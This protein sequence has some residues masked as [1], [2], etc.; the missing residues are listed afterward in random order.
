MLGKRLIILFFT[1]YS[2]NAIFA[3]CPTVAANF[4]VNQSTFCG[5]G[6]HTVNFANTSSGSSLTGLTFS[7]YVNG[8]LF[9]TTTALAQTSTYTISGIGDYTFQLIVSDPSIP[10]TDTMTSIVSILAPPT[11]SFTIPPGSF[12]TNNAVAFTN[13]S[14]NVYPSTTYLWNFGDGGTSTAANPVYSYATAGTYTV[15]LTTSNGGPCTSVSTQ[16][17]TIINGPQISISGDD[18]DGDVT[19][20]LFPADNTTSEIVTFSNTTTNAVSYS[21]N[22]GD[23]SPIFNTTSTAPFTHLYSSYGTY[24][25]T[26][27]ATSAN[28]CQDTD[29]LIVIFEKY[30]SS[31][32]TLHITEYSGCI[33]HSITTLTNLSVNASLFTWNFGDGTIITTTS[34]VPPVHNYLIGGIYTITLT[35]ANS[36]NTSNATISPITIISGPTANFTPSLFNGCAPQNVTFVNTSSNVQPP[37]NYQWNM[38][39]GNTYTNVITPPGQLYNSSGTYT[40]QLIAGNACGHDTVEQTIVMDTIPEIELDLLPNEGCSPLTVDPNA[41]QTGGFNNTWAWAIDGAFYSATP[42]DI[43]NQVFTAT[44]FTDTSLHTIQVTVSNVCGTNSDIDTVIVHPPVSANFVAVDTLCTNSTLNFTNLSLG[45]DLSYVWDFGDGSPLSTAT[46]PSHI[47]TAAGTYTVSLT[48]TGFC[49][50][51]VYTET[52]VVVDVPSI[53]ISASPSV[54]CNNES[55]TF[56]NLSSSSG[57]FNWNFGPSASLTTSNLYTPPSVTFFGSNVTH[58]VYFSI[59]YGGCNNIDSLDIV[60]NTSPV[61]S[62][63]VTPNNGC[64]PISVAINNT[65]PN[66]V[67]QTYNWD[68]GNGGTSTGISPLNQTYSSVTVDTVYQIALLVENA[69]GCLDSAFQSIAVYSLPIADFTLVDDTICAGQASSVINNSINASQYNWNFGDGNTGTGANPAHAFALPGDYTIQMIAQTNNNCSDTSYQLIH[70]DSLPITTFSANSVCFG[71]PTI[72]TQTTIS[73]Q[74]T[75]TWDFGD[76]SALFTGTNPQHAY[77]SAGTYTATLTALN[78]YGCSSL[79][80]YSVVVQTSPAPDFTWAPTC[81]GSA[82]TFS[83]LTPGFFMTH[84]WNFGDGTSQTGFN[85]SHIY[86]DTGTYFVTLVSSILLGCADSIT[87]PVYVDSIPTANFNFVPTCSGDSMFFVNTSIYSPA[88]YSWDFGDGNSSTL[89]S[90]GHVYP[91]ANTYTVILTV[92]YPITGCFHQS[93]QLVDAHPHTIPNF[94]VANFCLNDSTQF[95]DLTGNSPITWEWDFG[96]GSP[97]ETLSSPSHVFGLPGT[98]SI[99]LVTTNIFGCSDTLLSPIQINDLPVAQFSATTVCQGANTTF[100]NTSSNYTNSEWNF[101]DGSPLDL[102]DSPNYIY[103]TDS[104]YSVQLIVSSGFGCLDTI[105]QNVVVNPNPTA[106]YLPDSICFGLS[107]TFSD[108]SIDAVSWQYDFGDGTFA[109]N[110]NETHTYGSPGMYI[111]EQ[112]VTN[113]FGC[114]DSLSIPIEV[115][116]LPVAQFSAQTVCEDDTTFFV[117]QSIGT[118]IAWNWD[119]DDNGSISSLQDP[120]YVYTIGNTFNVTLIV[121]DVNNCFDTINVPVQTVAKPIVDFS[122]DTVCHTAVTHFTDLSNDP[123]G[124]ASWLYTFGE[125]ANLSGAQNP[126]YIYQNPGNFNVQLSVTNTFG[127]IDTISHLITVESVPIADFEFD[128]VCY[129][130]ATQFTNLSIGNLNT[131]AWNF[132]DGSPQL[133]TINPTNGYNSAGSYVVHLIA[134]STFGCADTLSQG[135]SVLSSPASNFSWN[136][137]CLGA[138]MTFTNLTAGVFQN[139][140]WDFGDGSLSSVINPSHLYSDTGAFIVQLT[141]TNNLGCADSV[142]IPVYVDSVPTVDF[143][144][145]SQCS[146]DVTQFNNISTSNPSN[147]TWLFGDGTGSFAISPQHVY[148]TAGSYNVTLTSTYANGC[149]SQNS[150]VVDAYPHTLPNFNSAN[151][152]LNDT[153]LF[154]DLSSN[155]VVSWEWIFGDGSPNNSTPSP[156]HVYGTIGLYDVS[157]VTSNSFGCSDTL[158]QQIEIHALPQIAFTLNTPCEGDS[159]IFINN[160]ANFSVSQWNFGDGS[161]LN[162]GIAPSHLYASNGNY[163]VTLNLTSI[164]GCMASLQQN[165]TIHP[166]PVANFTVDSLCFGLTN[167]FTDQST[168]AVS[169]LY[170]FGDGTFG[171]GANQTHIYAQAGT[172]VSE[173]IVTNIF[174]CQDSISETVVVYALPIANFSA[175]TVCEDA[176][177]TFTDLS[178]A[179]A[180][181]WNWDFDDNGNT[182]VT[183]NTSYVYANAGSYNVS[184]IVATVAGC[185]DTITQNVTTISKPTVDFSFDT[186]CHGSPT[187]FLSLATDPLGISSWN[188]NLGEN[189]NQSGAQNPNYIYSSPGNFTVLLTATNT[190]GCSDTIS[191]TIYVEDIPAPAFATDTVCL[192]NATTFND[193]STGVINT[194]NWNFGDGNTANSAGTTTHTYPTAGSFLATLELNAGNLC[195]QSITHAVLV[196][197]GIN[198]VIN[199]PVNACENSLVQFF[200]VTPPSANV[201]TNWL[202]NFGDGN[203]STLSNPSHSYATFGN[204]YVTLTLTTSTGCMGTSGVNLQILPPPSLQINSNTVCLGQNTNLSVQ[205]NQLISSWTWNFGDGS[206]FSNIQSPSHVYPGAGNYTITLDVL[207][208]NGCAGQTSTVVTIY[209]A[210]IANFIYQPACPG[211]AVNFTNT[212][213]GSITNYEWIY[214]G[215]TIGITPDIAY[216]FPD[217]I[218]QPSVSLVVISPLGCS[219]TITQTIQSHPLVTFNFGPILA[220][221]CEPFAAQ[222]EDQSTTLGGGIVNWVWDF[223]DGYNAFTQNPS[224]VYTNSGNYTIELTVTTAEGCQFSEV[225]NYQVIVYPAPIAGFN[226]PPGSYDLN[227]AIIP[228]TD[229]SQGAMNW[230]WDFGDNNYSNESNPTHTYLDS[231]VFYVTQIVYN[232]YGCADTAESSVYIQTSTNIYVPNAFT[233]NGNEWNE[234]FNVKGIGLNGYLLQIYDRWGVLIHTVHDQNDGWQGDYKGQPCQDGVYNWKLIY[235]DRFGDNQVMYGHVTLLR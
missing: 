234:Y 30:V 162:L 212:S 97:I 137:T 11:S 232:Q 87:I 113:I 82:M 71:N 103:A 70:I 129:G 132:G 99:S 233:P 116:S 69:S 24:T 66:I 201:I 179:N 206:P 184:L 78:G 228:F 37:N 172:F 22:F 191:H 47:F 115:F 36:C 235:R 13:T 135:V 126:N 8:F 80:T 23:G 79:S 2:T 196:Y 61:A 1:F 21:W 58:T 12:C 31:S 138:S 26:M 222:F 9:N 98:Y 166:N 120:A 77:A 219:D 91:V 183:E 151:F 144:F 215:N 88:N 100:T 150:H 62:F 122:F 84:T 167:T 155:S 68:Y 63:T 154:T 76:G 145:T 18:G 164:D 38:G 195:P 231:G 136:Q 45:S 90:P 17:I 193:Q 143:T 217:S 227:E 224:H 189:G 101:G 108:L 147:Y 202:W 218:L 85:A 187:H 161:P 93:T 33:P 157:L 7:W 200:D 42:N 92:T 139:Y 50:S 89:S 3:N 176:V 128:T 221:G 207:A 127:C 169:W 48:T 180:S 43:P 223:G 171:N 105:I 52:V 6:S 198:P 130:N 73:F 118:V 190:F 194:W 153:T 72:F 67:G 185:S 107:N 41:T 125:N 14:A 177:M 123:I 16:S 170:D 163:P 203:T 188:Y 60:L 199:A 165:A 205:T 121:S 64:S 117:D 86:A 96:D 146:G 54:I 131:Y 173:Q 34:P 44:N 106:N 35:A 160:S 175:N 53:S 142:F 141:T 75:Y 140:A 25:A 211:D 181:T 65:T 225:L 159:T 94:S 213:T 104:T 20:C 148:T 152:C 10:C 178:S 32:L 204:Y 56:T 81:L 110:P 49:G 214:N 112:L 4:T 174:G 111:T 210:P 57:I 29:T 46:N 5:P 28:G 192:G 59:N 197:Q 39:N 158:T 182:A 55:V 74:T 220:S 102:N 19:Y 109:T 230:Q 114:Q 15:T 95:T 226:Y 186:V 133:S 51:D 124:I 209:P 119:F 40:V 83:N 229:L 156:S 27:T 168:N 134:T 149:S 216:A 208:S